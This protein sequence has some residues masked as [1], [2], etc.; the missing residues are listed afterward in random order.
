MYGVPF[1]PAILLRVTV[2]PLVHVCSKSV[3][4]VTGAPGSVISTVL[5][6]LQADVPLPG[7][8]TVIVYVP[9]VKLNAGLAIVIG[10]VDEVPAVITV[11]AGA[12][13]PYYIIKTMRI[14]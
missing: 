7:S 2:F 6:S 5:V 1:P 13:P 9:T 4:K 3:S 12:G 8:V 10:L 14:V 11:L